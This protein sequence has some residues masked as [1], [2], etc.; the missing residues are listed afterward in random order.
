MHEEAALI[1]LAASFFIG[2]AGVF[3]ICRAIAVITFLKKQ[4]PV[5]GIFLS[6]VSLH[7]QG[8]S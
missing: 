2:I 3:N 8:N 6:F 4:S 7:P 5:T 1:S